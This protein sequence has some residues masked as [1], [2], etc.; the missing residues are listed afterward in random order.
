MTELPFH[1]RTWMTLE[2]IHATVYFSPL[3]GPAYESIGLVGREGYFAGRSAAMGT[4]SAEVVISTFFNFA[5]DLVR[6]CIPH[7]WSKATPQ[8]I[9][10]TRHQFIAATF[11]QFCGDH[12]RSDATTRAAELA[13]SIALDACTRVEGRPLFAAHASLPWPDDS[14][15]AMVLWHAQ[16]LLRE[17]R[18]DGH[19]ALL[20]SEGL[21][22]VDAHV[23]HIAT[24]T[25]PVD[26]MRGTRAWSDVAYQNAVES[27]IERGLVARA[28][29]GALSLTETGLAQRQRIEDMTDEL[30]A[31]PYRAAGEAACAELRAAGR[32]FSQALVDAG[33]SP[34]R[35]LPPPEAQA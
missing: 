12:V 6:Q 5:P 28:D 19:I 25:M 1:R 34:M 14:N 10:E 20:V 3:A 35:R 4:P 33:L 32:P 23:T 27:L 11:E 21:S 31:A 15:P 2:P 22:G 16:T 13:K 29:D 9:L 30:A 17:Y 8:Q 7:A 26:L 24:G 18:G